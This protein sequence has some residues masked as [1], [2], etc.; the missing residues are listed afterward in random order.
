MSFLALVLSVNACSDDDPEDV[1][2]TRSSPSADFT[3]YQTFRFT[4]EEDMPAGVRG[5]DLPSDV[6]ANLQ[7][8]NEAM[9][10]ELLEEGLREVAPGETPDVFAFSLAS[11]DEEAALYW[12]CVDGYWYGY[13]SFAWDPCAWLQPVY[14]E[15]E[16]G[17]IV[18]GLADPARQEIVYGSVIEGLVTGDED[19]MESRLEDDMSEA[20]DDYPSTQ[21]GI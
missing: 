16:T 12:G 13:W 17:T 20:F 15:Y 3:S 6:A 14:A 4:T 19:D 9:R 18:V 2:T 10:Q 5:V 8:V 11:T 7:M 21:T 1:V